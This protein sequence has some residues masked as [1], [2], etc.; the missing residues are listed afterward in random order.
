M[1]SEKAR[2]FIDDN[3]ILQDHVPYQSIHP[4][5]GCRAVELAEQEAEQRMSTKAV[6]AF[7]HSMSA[8]PTGCDRRKPNGCKKRCLALEIFIQKLNE[9]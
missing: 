2:E 7:C 1:K 8:G 3:V 4:Q 5:I 6:E 9:K